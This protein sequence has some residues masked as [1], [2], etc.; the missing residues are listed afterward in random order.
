VERHGT[1]GPGHRFTYDPGK[2]ERFGEQA[3]D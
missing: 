1:G 3:K 2:V